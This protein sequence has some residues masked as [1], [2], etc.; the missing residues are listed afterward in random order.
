MSKIVVWEEQFKDRCVVPFL[1]SV[2]CGGSGGQGGEVA[3]C[4]N[5]SFVHR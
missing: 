4:S 5:R 1:V 2:D 3:G